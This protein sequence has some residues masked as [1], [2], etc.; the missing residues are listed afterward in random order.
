MTAA[1][2]RSLPFAIALALAGCSA[3]AGPRFS[4]DHL[5]TYWEMVDYGDRRVEGPWQVFT[6]TVDLGSGAFREVY[7]KAE[8]DDEKFPC[9]RCGSRDCRFR[10]FVEVSWHTFRRGGWGSVMPWCWF[11]NSTCAAYIYVS[12]DERKDPKRE[13]PRAK[14]DRAW[15]FCFHERAIDLDGLDAGAAYHALIG[16]YVINCKDFPDGDWGANWKAFLEARPQVV[17]PPAAAPTSP[18]SRP[19]APR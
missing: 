5:G 11:S 18:T 16:E 17:R 4:G 8:G 6:G 3:P 9:A 10:R 7:E 14:S 1:M 13:C 12:I 19:S 15:G 2:F